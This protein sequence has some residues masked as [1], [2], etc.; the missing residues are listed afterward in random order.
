M[1]D[2]NRFSD[3]FAAVS[4]LGGSVDTHYTQVDE[5]NKAY[6]IKREKKHKYYLRAV[7]ST[8]GVLKSGFE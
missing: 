2:R 5:N 6:T 1:I 7:D 4:W 3:T 8:G